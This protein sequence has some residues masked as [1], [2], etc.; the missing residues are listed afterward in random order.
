MAKHIRLP[1]LSFEHR[2]PKLAS[3]SFARP[4]S[5]GQEAIAARRPQRE[6][7]PRPQKLGAGQGFLATSLLVAFR[8][9]CSPKIEGSC[10][11]ESARNRVRSLG[12][13][14]SDA[15][16]ILGIPAL[17]GVKSSH[18]DDLDLLSEFLITG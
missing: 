7:R 8:P 11:T 2:S 15:C 16:A 4:D 9:V 10:E 3:M 18:L 12:P 14:T 6:R 5:A 1:S 17:T 13:A